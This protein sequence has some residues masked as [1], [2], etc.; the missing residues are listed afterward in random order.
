MSQALDPLRQQLARL[1][2]PFEEIDVDLGPPEHLESLHYL[3]VSGLLPLSHA[4][5]IVQLFWPI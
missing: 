3:F 2:D 1:L 4:V 5:V